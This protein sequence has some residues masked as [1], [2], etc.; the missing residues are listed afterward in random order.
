MLPR[1]RA[2]PDTA[3]D[4][5]RSGARLCAKHQPQHVGACSIATSQQ[6]P[7]WRIRKP[8]SASH[9][10][11]PNHNLQTPARLPGI[12]NRSL[13]LLCAVVACSIATSQPVPAGEI[14]SNNRQ[15]T[16]NLQATAP[17]PMRGGQELK[18]EVWSFFARLSLVQLQLP[19]SS[20]SITRFVVKLGF[21]PLRRVCDS[22]APGAP[23]N[24]ARRLTARAVPPFLR[25]RPCGGGMTPRPVNPTTPGPARPPCRQLRRSEM[26]VEP[27]THRYPS[28]VGGMALS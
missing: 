15:A 26:Y 8:Q 28:P 10:E 4:A 20:P 7:G 6:V 18:I 25:R 19:N 1:K 16:K 24:A 22:A 17:K 23:L 5:H 11:P 21:R 14:S 12:E 27:K 3:P 9:K 2:P 13:E